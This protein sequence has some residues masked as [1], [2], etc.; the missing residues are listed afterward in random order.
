MWEGCCITVFPYLC[1]FGG[2]GGVGAGDGWGLLEE[3]VAEVVREVCG[4]VFVWD[5]CGPRGLSASKEEQTGSGL[6]VRWEGQ[7]GFIRVGV[8][9]GWGVR[10]LIDVFREK[11]VFL[12]FLF[13]ES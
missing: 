2:G 1:R 7:A 4:N 5:V 13:F 3:A 6:I 8:V 10:L 9:L 12:D 11:N